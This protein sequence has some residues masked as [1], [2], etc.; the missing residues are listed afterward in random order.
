[1]EQTGMCEAI[2]VEIVYL[3]IGVGS[4]LVGALLGFLLGY[5][6]SRSVQRREWRRRDLQKGRDDIEVLGSCVVAVKQEIQ[7]N[8][9]LLLRKHEDYVA[10]VWDPAL[11]QLSAVSFESC[12]PVFVEKGL[13][14]REEE[15]LRDVNELFR[16]YVRL[17]QTLEHLRNVIMTDRRMTDATKVS[18]ASLV[19]ETLENNL[20]G[21]AVEALE[22][23]ETELVNRKTEVDE[24]LNRL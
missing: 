4:A 19:R 12:W 3:I 17:N 8:Q 9:E 15:R 21:T 24:E 20:N 18:L 2:P 5:R 1:M 10:D 22:E 14:V 13:I 7:H 16:D 11:F 6:T 23:I